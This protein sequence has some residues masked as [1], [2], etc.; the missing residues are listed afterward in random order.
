MFFRKDPGKELRKI[1]I[2]RDINVTELADKSG[3][4]TWTISA[5][6]HGRVNRPTRDT[7]ELLS[8]ALGV[9]INKIW[10]DA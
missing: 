7:K 5:I 3:V 8:D 9:R 1:M 10:P 6:I 2:D 4:S